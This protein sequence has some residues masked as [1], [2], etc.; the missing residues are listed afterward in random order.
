MHER[1]AVTFELGAMSQREG[2]EISGI[3]GYSTLSQ[4][5]LTIDF[6]SGLVRIGDR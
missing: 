1:E 2:V 4:G 5:P 6:R 3:L